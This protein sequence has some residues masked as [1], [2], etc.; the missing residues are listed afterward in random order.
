MDFSLLF[1]DKCMY[2]QLYL[3]NVKTSGLKVVNTL[4][5]NVNEN[6]LQE[7]FDILLVN[8]QLCLYEQPYL[9]YLKT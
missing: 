8:I 1:R 4:P 9:W 2:E 5:T 3:L 7:T 6:N